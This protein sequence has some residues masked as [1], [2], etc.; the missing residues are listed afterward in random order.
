LT[1]LQGAQS[2]GPAAIVLA[3]KHEPIAALGE[4]G[5]KALPAPGGLIYDLK[6]ILAPAAESRPDLTFVKT[7]PGPAYALQ[8]GAALMGLLPSEPL[9]LRPPLLTL[10]RLPGLESL[11]HGSNWVRF[12]ILTSPTPTTIDSRKEP[13]STIRSN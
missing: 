11:L 8:P 10:G 4:T 6:G 9:L 5:V 7:T 12:A 3:V 13:K 2:G 1:N